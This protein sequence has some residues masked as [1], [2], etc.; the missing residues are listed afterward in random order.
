MLLISVTS[1]FLGNNKAANYKEVVEKLIQA[2][3][4]IGCNIFLKFLLLSP[5]LNFFPSNCGEESDE[6]GECF[7][8]L[9]LWI[10]DIKVNGVYQCLQK[11][12]R[13]L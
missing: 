4:H 9:E 5:H 2:Y 8:M 12:G 13:Q 1:N 10:K 3:K 11:T 7:K 6:H